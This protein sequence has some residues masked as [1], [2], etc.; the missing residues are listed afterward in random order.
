MPLFLKLVSAE[1][2]QIKRFNVLGRKSFFDCLAQ[3]LVG[4]HK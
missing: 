1:V 2:P 4:F 3:F